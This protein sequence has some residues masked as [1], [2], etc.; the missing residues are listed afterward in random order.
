MAEIKIEGEA[1]NLP[2]EIRILS[3]I[4]Y[5]PMLFFL[6][7]IVRPK[8]GFC[9]FHGIQSLVLLLALAIVWIAVYILDFLL[10]KVLGNMILLGFVF[11]ITA[12][13]VHNV[14][15]FAISVLYILLI[16]YCFIQAAAGQRWRVPFL[17]AYAQ[18]LH[19]RYE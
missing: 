6:P 8:D 11:K 2:Q 4:G 14:A 1:E 15:G 9:R 16:T 7:L 12:W 18:R 13:L 19:I 3:A 5:L 17:G 10:G